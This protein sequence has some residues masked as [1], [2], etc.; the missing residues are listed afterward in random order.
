MFYFQT[1]LDK[2]LNY[3]KKIFKKEELNLLLSN[4]FYPHKETNIENIIKSWTNLYIKAVKNS[5]Q[6]KYKTIKSLLIYRNSFGNFKNYNYSCFN[7]RFY[8]D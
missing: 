4:A 5:Y 6:N 7:N 2:S 3:C 8:N 1:I